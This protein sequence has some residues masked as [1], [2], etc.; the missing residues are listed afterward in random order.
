MTSLILG[1]EL[2]GGWTVR[3]IAGLV[4]VG[5]LVTVIWFKF[6]QLQFPPEWEHE[7]PKPEAPKPPEPKA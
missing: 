2:G 6:R 3:E 7:D 5:I 1:I 4:F